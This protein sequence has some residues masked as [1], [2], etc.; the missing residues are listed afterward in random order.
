MRRHV[1]DRAELGELADVL[2]RPLDEDAAVERA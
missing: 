2:A 1:D